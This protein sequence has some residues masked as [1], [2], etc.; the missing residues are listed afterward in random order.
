FRMWAPATARSAGLLWLRRVRLRFRSILLLSLSVLAVFLEQHRWTCSVRAE[1]VEQ[2][3]KRLRE[4]PALRCRKA[5]DRG[6]QPLL[7]DG[8]RLLQGSAAGARERELEAPR[9]LA[10]PLALDKTGVDEP[11]DDRR[12]RA[13]IG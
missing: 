2:A 6:E 12:D 3:L 13:L 5:L 7:R 10:C 8:R 1:L 9:V 4:P 11:R